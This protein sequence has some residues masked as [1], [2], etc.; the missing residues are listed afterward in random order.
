MKTEKF[1]ESITYFNE[2]KTIKN[3]I[4]DFIKKNKFTDFSPEGITSYLTFRHPISDL[5]MF[6]GY[7]KIKFGGDNKETTWHPRFDSSTDSL[8]AAVYKIEDLLMDSI[9]DLTKGLE[10]IAVTISGGLDS[11]LITAIVRKLYPEKKIYSYCAGFYGDDEFEYA[12]IVAHNN[13]TIYKEI[14]LNRDDFLG[15]DSILPELIEFKGSPLHP[16]ELPLAIVEK[17]AKMDGMQIVLCGEGADD[18]FGGY[19]QNFCMYMNYD[20]KESF[21]KYFL[22]NYRY[23]SLKDRNIIKNEYLVDDFDLMMKDIEPI[24]LSTDIR[25]WALYFIQ[26]LHTP[27]LITRGANAMRYNGFPLGFP[28]IC[29]KLISYVNSLPFEYKVAWK[30][31]KDKKQADN[32]P[33]RDISEKHDIPKMILKRLAEKYLAHKII[34]RQKKGF[35]IPFEFWLKDLKT[36]DLN[37]S[38]FKTNDISGYNGWKKFML[39]NLNTFINIFEK[40]KK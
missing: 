31:E 20:H 30:S 39:I 10:R 9:K 35:P 23:F 1:G 18:I 26:K 17:K 34:Y 36:W 28:F 37:K 12:R 24:E 13:N 38:I 11:S 5:T 21:F 19:G 32:T 27:G 15:K 29:D 2:N 22:D 33:Y 4:S 6:K 3:N 8:D 25:N 40:Y 14:I 7:R 16:N